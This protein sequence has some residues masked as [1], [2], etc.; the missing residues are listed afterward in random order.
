MNFC[1]APPFFSHFEDGKRKWKWKKNDWNGKKGPHDFLNSYKIDFW[2]PIFIKFPFSLTTVPKNLNLPTPEFQ[3]PKSWYNHL[4]HD[5][6]I[7]EDELEEEVEETTTHHEPYPFFDEES[8]Q[9]NVTAQLG[10]DTY[11]HC[12]VENLGEKIVSISL[13]G[14]NTFSHLN[15]HANSF[16][17]SIFQV[18]W[19]RR[20]GDQLHLITFGDSLYSSDSRYSLKFK[21]PNDW[22][23]HIQYANER[24]EGQFECQINTSPT[25]VF[26]VSLIVVGK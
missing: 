13:A 2:F 3:V 20:K 24:D 14:R 6:D 11:L 22:Q 23:L 4:P 19:V 26:V 16:C 8:T 10:S 15:S 12:R 25:L 18:S 7:S 1:S 5:V 17:L 21:S 9:V